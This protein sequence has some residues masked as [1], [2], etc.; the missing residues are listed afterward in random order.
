MS[1]SIRIKDGEKRVAKQT[2]DTLRSELHQSHSEF[3]DKSAQYLDEVSVC[4]KACLAKVQV[5]K[6]EADQHFADAMHHEQFV[7]Q[8][9]IAKI[10]AHAE[11]RHSDAM[12]IVEYTLKS[13]LASTGAQAERRHAD[14]MHLCKSSSRA[15]FAVALDN[16]N[17]MSPDWAR[18]IDS[19]AAN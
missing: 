18:H 12:H 13:R 5:A 16:L 2:S 14:A 15:G 19:D 1:A 4:R 3:A 9:R 7:V 11:Q 17:L 6:A 10:E 8:E